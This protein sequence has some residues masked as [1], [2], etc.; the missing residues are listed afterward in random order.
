MTHESLFYLLES[1]FN[2]SHNQGFSISIIGAGIILGAKIF[3][4]KRKQ[5]IH[6][7]FNIYTNFKLLEYEQA[8]L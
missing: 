4:V 8:A 3:N 6:F 7:F 1:T 5:E 2:A